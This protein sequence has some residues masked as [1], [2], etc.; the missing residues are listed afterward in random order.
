ML[1]ICVINI[2]F[3]NSLLFFVFHNVIDV[4]CGVYELK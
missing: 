4:L 3:N 1:M 2:C